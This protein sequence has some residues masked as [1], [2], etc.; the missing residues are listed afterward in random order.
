MRTQRCRV[1][2]ARI[3]TTIFFLLGSL[4]VLNATNFVVTNG[5]NAGAGSLRQAI[6]DANADV[7]APHNITFTV[8]GVINITSSLPTITRQ[9]T[10]DGANLVTISGPGGDNT[11]ALFVLGSGSG[12]STIRNLTMRNTGL[13]PVRLSVALSGVTI[14]NM[15]FTQTGAHYMNRGILAN[16]AVTNLTIRNVQVLNLQ[17]N[18]QG[19]YF[20]GAVTNLLID[21]YKISGGGG[22]TATGIY[23][24]G[25]ANGVTVKNS[26]IDMDDI[27]TAD[28]GNNGI[29]FAGTA[30]NVT[31]DSSAFHDCESYGVL[32]GGVTT[33]FTVKNSVFDNLD[34]SSAARLIYFNSN[35]NTI[36][37]DSNVLDGDLRNTINDADYA[38]RMPAVNNQNVTISNNRINEH[39]QYGIYIGANHANNNDNF[40]I[41][42][43]NFTNNGF[44]GDA[45]GA[46]RFDARNTTS[47]GGPVLVTENTFVNTTGVAIAVFPGNTASYI[48]PNF[49]ISENIIYNTKSTFGAI[50]VNY[51]DKVVITANSIYNNQGL[52]IELAGTTGANCGYEGVN[53]PQILTSTETS[54]GV[55]DVAVKMPAICGSGNCSVEIF[56]NEAGIK[57]VGGQHYVVTKTG[58]ASGNQTLTGI[59]GAFPEITGAP[60]GTWTATLRINNNCGTSEFSNKKAIKPNGPAGISNG[61][62]VWL[63]GDELSVNNAEP[64]ASGQTITGWEEFSGVGPSATTIINNPLT[65]LSGINFN[66]VADMDGDGIRGIFPGAPS[67]ITTP[68]TTS[69]AVFN[70]LS[71]TASND[72][73]YCLFSQA[74]SDFNTN[75]AQIEFWRTGNNINAYRGN[76]LLNPAI[77]GT[78]GVAAFDKPGVFSSL[79]SA[80][81]HSYNY[82]GLNMG[83]SNYNKG[84]FAISQWFVGTGWNTTNSWQGGS[85]TDFAEVFTYNRVLSATELQKVQS[86]MAM[87]YGIAIKQNYVLSSGTQVWD[88][89]A[90][91]THS[92]EIA[93]LVKDNLSVLHQKQARAFQSDEVV[94]IGLGNAIAVTNNTNDNTVTNDLSILIWGND[95]LSTAYTQPFTAGTYSITRMPR[96]WKVGKTNWTDQDITLQLKNGKTSNYLL[97][98]TDPAFA[99]ITQELQLSNTGTI[100][101]SSS[102][103]ASGMYFTFGRQQK[104]PG[105]VLN[106][107]G[108]WTKADEGVGL[109]GT[110]AIT[111]EDQGPSQRIWS[112]V[113]TNTLTW[114][115]AAMNYNP[116]IQFPGPG[117]PANYFSYSP[118]FTASYTQGEAF[119][120]QSSTVNTVAG[121][122]WH[123][124]GSS[125]ATTIY[126]RFTDNNMY[127]HFGTNARRSFSFGT[128]NMALPVILNVNSAS[129]SWTASLD[130]RVYSG[131]AAYPTSFAQ[132]GTTNAIGVGWGSYFNGPVSEVILYNRKLNATERQQLNSYLAIRY[133]ITIEQTTPTDYIASDGTTIMWKASDNTGFNNN[134]AGI[135]RD[136]IG[137][138]YQKQS[139]SINT[140]ASGNLISLAIGN[141]V[142]VSNAENTDSI[143][144]NKS[145]LVWGDNNGAITYTTNTTGANATVRMPRVWKVDKLNWA[146]K[147][148]TIKLHGS[149]TNTYLLISNSDATFA[150]IDQELA[151][152]SDSTVTLNS[153]LLPD[154]A[155]FT[156]GKEIKG[157]G[158]VNTGVQFW[159]RADD[160]ISAIDH[161]LDY[162][163]NDN[164]AAQPTAANQPAAI[165]SSTNF[166]PA[167]NLDGNNDFMNF[168]TNA[169][170]SGTNQFTILSVTRRTSVGTTDVILGQQTDA[171]NSLTN[172]FSSVNKYGT[173]PVNVGSVAS[174][175]TYSIAN[176][177]YINATTRSAGNLFNLY[178]NGAGDGSGTQP[179]T[180]LT[181]NLRIG[182][183]GGGGADFFGGHVNELVVYNRAL[184]APELQ[185]VNSYLGLKYG[186]TL[187]NGTVNYVAT[188]GTTNMWTVAKNPGYTNNIAGL[189]RDDKTALNQKQSRS[190]SD[191]TITIAAGTTVATDN[192]SNNSTIDDLS[193]FT[194]ADNG[195]ALTFSVPVTGVPNATTRM[196][197]V[198]KVDRTNW[199]DQDITIK[200]IQGGERYLLVN[201][202][203]P[204][205]GA[206]TTEYPIS[207]LA[208]TL[209]VNSSNLPDGAYFTLGTKIVGPGCVNAGIAAWFRSDYGAGVSSW[210]DFSGNQ[211]NATQA[212]VVNQ[213]GM[214]TSGLNFNPA[215]T[216]NGSNQ[217]LVIPNALT[218]GKFSFGNA[219]RTVIGVGATSIAAPATSNM[220]FTY[221]ANG[222]GT[223]T[224]VGQSS[225]LNG[226]AVFG[227][228]NSGTYNVIGATGTIPL[229]NTRIIGGRYSGTT[230]SLDVN[231]QPGGS[232][233]TTWNTNSAQNAFIGAGA[234]ATTNYWNGKTGEVIVYNRELNASELQRVNSYLGIKYGI[235]INGGTGDYLASDGTTTMWKA[236]DNA[237][238]SNRITGIGRD[239]CTELYQKQSLSADAGIVTIAIGDVVE[240]TNLASANAI[241]NNNSY[242]VFADDNAA[243]QYNTP[244]SGLQDLTARMARVW[245]ADKTNWADAGVTF[246]LTGGN[247]KIHMIVS[248][249]IVFDGSDAAY[250]LDI[251]GN[252]TIPTDDIPDG[253][254]FS[255]AKALNGP[256]Y[257]NVGVQLWMRADDNLSTIDSWLDYSGNDNHATQPTV[258]N[259]PVAVANSV[260]YNPAFDFDGTNDYMDFA[261]NGSISGTN[262]F[263]VV[264]VQVRNTVGTHDAVLAQGPPVNGYLN[265][266]TS[267]N[268]YGVAATGSTTVQSMGTYA[269]ANV[270]DIGAHTR[271]GNLFSLYHNG[272]AD[273]S[274]TQPYNFLA[275]NLRI[276][277]RDV[278]ADVAFDGHIN[279]VIV[280]NR[281]LSTPELRQVHSYLALKYGIT[282]AGDYIGTDGTTSYWTAANNT[283]HLNNIAGIGRDDNTGLNQK[284]SRSVNTA[285]NGNMV[286]IGL[287]TIEA[288]NKDNT[289]TFDD[290]LQFLVWGDNGLTGTKT[291][292][293]PVALDPGACSKITRLQREW[294]VQKTGNPGEVRVQV[295]LAGLVPSS[296]GAGDLKLLID[297]DGDFSSGVT[298]IVNPTS[299]D[300]VTQVV[301]FDGINFANGQYFTVVTDLTNQAPGGV[302]TNLYTWHRADKGVTTATGVST[303][304]DQSVSLKDVA[305]AT[306][307]SQPAYNTTSNLIN[308]NPNLGFDGVN[309]VIANSTLSHS[310]TANGED[311]FAVVVPNAVAGFH[312]V[313]GMGTLASTNTATE[314]RFNTNRLEYLANNV[315]PQF[316]TNPAATTGLVQI[317]NGHR[318]NAGVASLLL[319][320]NTV[321]SGTIAQNPVANYLNIGA[322]RAAAANNFFFNG[323][324]AEVVIYNRQLNTTE[325]QQVASYLAVKYGVTLPHNYLDPSGAIIWDATTNTGFGNNIT[326]IGR[327]DCNGLHQKQSKSVN[328]NEALVTV[329]NYTGI[330]TTNAGNPNTLENNSSLLFGDNNGNRTVWTATAAPAG[331][332]RLARTWKTEEHGTLSTMTIQVPANSSANAVKLPLEKDGI[333]YLL[334][335]PTNDFVN[336]VTEVPMTLNGTDWETTFDFSSGQYFTFATNDACVSTDALLANYNAVTTSSLDKCYVNG[337]IYFKDPLDV[338]KYIAAIYDPTAII[339]RAQVTA[340]VN[341]NTPFAELGEG[342]SLQASRLMRRMLQIDCNNC[343]DAGANPNPNFTVRMYYSPV[344]KTDAESV[345]TN[346]M[347]SIKTANGITDPHDFKWF[348]ASGQNVAQVVAGLS[349]AGLTSAG[350]EWNDG[351]LPTGVEDGVDYIDFTAIN[352]F[353]VFGGIWVVNVPAVLPVTWLN[354]QAIPSG[355]QTI[356]VKWK[357]VHE[358]N[359]AG[360]EVERSEDGINFLSIVSV[361]PQPG[362][363][364]DPLSYSI[365]DN[366]V[367]QGVTYYYRIRQTNTDGRFSYSRTVTSKLKAGTIQYV[368]VAP[369]PTQAETLKWEV[370]VSKQQRLQASIIDMSGKLLKTRSLNAQAGG[371]TY[372]VDINGWKRGTYLLRIEDEDGSVSIGKFIVL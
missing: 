98:S 236:S 175:G 223:G 351:V 264:G 228:Y 43:N 118:Q 38:I 186:I 154:G 232:L 313:I 166:N 117:G 129:N 315:T 341:V 137:A 335:S 198:W 267:T 336:D 239:D 138:L 73:F 354:V 16:A 321:G 289:A 237:G 64:T 159:L 25:A 92:K 141:E 297:D 187:A 220:M 178:T 256:G 258:A 57:G 322:R 150:V 305:Q 298:T 21:G 234:P 300:D 27:A 250:Q 253:A 311:L 294:K 183:R 188:D 263:T 85:E 273:G 1:P 359:N 131:P 99:T 196:A 185:Q 68:T 203:D 195:N 3:A 40:T 53:T 10:I 277:N 93:A 224:F 62:A 202:T 128:K 350:Q 167:F 168:A 79:T 124:G 343:Y 272:S 55:Y 291:T 323:R 328:A 37:I 280:Y 106:G 56:S 308:F 97:I 310:A 200:V 222:L 304:A 360:F 112:K 285:S 286:A 83:T 78:T 17:D 164:D 274:A 190:E 130:G 358:I 368:Q 153:S 172:F 330:Y 94:T 364:G 156:F 115:N 67:W 218:V 116:A 293:Y 180:F 165:P 245:K 226:A 214:T 66:P 30:S 338:T 35:T 147:N 121:F 318:S 103:L 353:S 270:P 221:G 145:F 50:R 48:I 252:V 74:G 4:T 91:A 317:A 319:N 114:N 361:M 238:Y 76:T 80:T 346:N 13:E 19:L 217:F 69:V 46:L 107:L 125:G 82:N 169:G 132:V 31:I 339:N 254:Y 9:V 160:N 177:P 362:N 60:Y 142:A 111:W 54:P 18:V 174:T 231:G 189:G 81:S 100:T 279:E 29:Y 77:P 58:V 135:A 15:I 192:A 251:N 363:P 278:A 146:D 123:L 162:S 32:C 90:N 134:I 265:Y 332:E 140:A 281:A 249:D 210:I 84:N 61:I 33:N 230:A 326:G 316:I 283:G 288:I 149:I 39:D 325:R 206:G 176:I 28:D 72:R 357:T 108:V 337:W 52:G 86:Y 163:G 161:W 127:L 8:T 105:G 71:I 247:D 242:F 241:A 20:G 23:I 139:R 340:T 148:I 248:A 356:T 155:Y 295:Y 303:W 260:N 47:D 22:G 261:T 179:Y 170:I 12:G 204:N 314:L 101:I 193:F 41:R 42:G 44:T 207:V 7:S 276:G 104:A 182:T 301:Y 211:T 113:N 215:L 331:R 184:N 284:Q 262:P 233:V 275:T 158:Y 369:N 352:S 201:A 296:T 194:W 334:V 365:N 320:G 229:N 2:A 171:T 122:P 212:T 205:F 287:T 65:K 87:K 157:P 59:T 89:T 216:F 126:Y 34:G 348:K 208:G 345:E 290:N 88:V 227:A 70:P 268:K 302:I 213:P 312:D 219:A 152:N 151:I 246:K 309:D 307:A 5:N 347:E 136:E 367:V 14:E 235:T 49:T 26:V 96:V 366:N 372:T 240:A 244:I 95:S 266:Y 197:R 6:M 333:V 133:G 327:D 143:T 306:A 173:G 181:N 324:V 110:N 51:V 342:N 243:V 119:S 120:V 282:M 24:V 209:T 102:L 75:F 344:E 329:G 199:T 45:W 259:Q 63:R 371:N 271:S 299:Y 191:S 225:V 355:P 349:P 255:F 36:L 292:E 269:T 109:T 144:N 370:Y 257:V 11:V